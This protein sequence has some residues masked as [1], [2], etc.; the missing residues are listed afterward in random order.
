MEKFFI[1]NEGD[2]EMAWNTKKEKYITQQRQ[3]ATWHD[4]FIPIFTSKKES[5][6]QNEGG[7]RDGSLHS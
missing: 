5:F 6:L 4:P 3:K 1:Q 7:Y 2:I